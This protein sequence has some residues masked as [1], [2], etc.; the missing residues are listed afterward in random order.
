[1]PGSFRCGVGSPRSLRVGWSGRTNDRGVHTVGDLVR[2]ADVDI[3][4]AGRRKAVVVLGDGQSTGD[5]ADIVASQSAVGRGEVV[6][7]NDVGD[8]EASAGLEDTEC[9]GEYGG[10]VG[11]QVDDAVGDHD[12]HGFGGQ[13]NR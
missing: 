10:L 6:F 7:G 4:E 9:F 2:R 3:G 11:G 13:R 1:M 5:A 12:V 8:A